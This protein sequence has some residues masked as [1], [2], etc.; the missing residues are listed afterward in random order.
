[1]FHP[2]PEQ[3]FTG[4]C[5]KSVFSYDQA[6]FRIEFKKVA[7]KS[8]GKILEMMKTNRFVTI[9]ELAEHMEISTRAVEKQIA[10][11]KDENRIRRV[12]GAKGG[13][14]EVIEA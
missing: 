1:M 12:G 11:L 6:G 9:A 3:F 2:D 5:K 8:S 14:W 10:N 7:E 4:A 13:H